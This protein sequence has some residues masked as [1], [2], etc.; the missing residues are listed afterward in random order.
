V[1]SGAADS[2]RDLL[3]GDKFPFQFAFFA[4]GFFSA[5]RYEERRSRF[6]S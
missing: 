4:F 6:L 2:S 1:S 3:I 5:E